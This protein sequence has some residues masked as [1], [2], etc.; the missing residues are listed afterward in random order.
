[1]KVLKNL[2]GND[3]KIDQ[4]CIY[5]N[6]TNE[7]QWTGKCLKGKKIYAIIIDSTVS[8]IVSKINALN[9]DDFVFFKGNARSIYRNTWPIPNYHTE[10]GYV[11][12]MQWID[13]NGLFSIGFGSFFSTT[14]VVQ[15][16]MEYTEK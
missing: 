13:A 7:K 8:E 4:T 12:T 15:I 11:I 5:F 2:F 10:S 14:G 16:I 3:S 6:Y 9:V 1:M